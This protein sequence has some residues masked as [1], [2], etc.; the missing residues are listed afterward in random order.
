MRLVCLYVVFMLCM[1]VWDVSVVC[2]CVC[3]VCLCEC[4]VR[5]CSVVFVRMVC[6]GGFLC[7][8]GWY[9]FVCGV[10]CV[11]AWVYVVG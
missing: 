5:E 11:V 2:V 9:I 6:V 10:W 8:L 3:V 7:V 1:C 4:G